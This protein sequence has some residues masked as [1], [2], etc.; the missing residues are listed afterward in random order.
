VF[1]LLGD[2]FVYRRLGVVHGHRH[3]V[4]TAHKFAAEVMLWI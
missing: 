2:S 4:F 1:D 3:R